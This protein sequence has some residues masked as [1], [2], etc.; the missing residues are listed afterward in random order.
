[1]QRCILKLRGIIYGGDAHFAARFFSFTGRA[2]Y[3]DAIATGRGCI[4]N[5]LLQMLDA[6]ALASTR[7]KNAVHLIYSKV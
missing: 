5:G 7:G 6:N 2:W 4:N 3:H 1:G